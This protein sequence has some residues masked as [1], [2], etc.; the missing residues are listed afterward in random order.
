MPIRILVSIV[1]LCL[2]LIP[3]AGCDRAPQAQA[4]QAAAA[5][6]PEVGVVV[7]S[8]QDVPLTT[9]LAGRTSP[10][11][12]AQVRPQVSGII[13]ERSFTEGSEVTKG[14]PLY[15]IDPSTYRAVYAN[16]KASLAV[17]VANAEPLGLKAKRYAELVKTGSV[18]QQDNDD[19]QAAHRQALAAIEAAEAALQSARIDL[20]HTT[21][22]APISGR[23]GASQATPGALVTANQSTALATIQQIDPIYVDVTQSSRDLLRLRRALADGSLARSNANA[24]AAKLLYEDDT[25]YALAGTLQFADLTVTEDTGVYT[26][27][28]LFPNPGHDLLPGMYVKAVLEEGVARQAILVPQKAVSRNPKGTPYVMLVAADGTVAQREFTADR[29]LGENWLATAGLKAG[30]TIVVEGLQKIRAGSKVT[31]VEA[32]TKAQQ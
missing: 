32:T 7:L 8:F 16:A 23:I 15:R 21:I 1:L 25:P 29:A 12:V 24:A 10:H 19:A 17:A 11:L 6:L 14:Q 26:L 31:T 4:Q 30:D 5:P 3:V 2:S 18:S 9:V 13:L 22:T 28:V 27:R 20:D